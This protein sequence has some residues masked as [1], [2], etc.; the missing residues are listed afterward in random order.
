MNGDN[1]GSGNN[2]VT[3]RWVWFPGSGINLATN[4]ALV[5]RKGSKA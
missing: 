3:G 2:A 5:V 1:A 4:G